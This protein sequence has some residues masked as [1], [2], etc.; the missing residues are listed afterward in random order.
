MP[1]S[2]ARIEK[3]IIQR[4]RRG[5]RRGPVKGTG[6][7]LRGTDTLGLG[8]ERRSSNRGLEENHKKVAD[9]AM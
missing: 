6:R 2:G 9:F 7:V 1:G 3:Q 8:C 5:I 4:E